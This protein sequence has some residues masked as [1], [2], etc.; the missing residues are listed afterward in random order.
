MARLLAAALLL[1]CA[2]PAAGGVPPPLRGA[3][4]GP[5]CRTSAIP[6]P[7]NALTAAAGALWLACRDGSRVECRGPSGSSSPRSG[8]RASGHGRLRAPATRCG[9]S[10]ATSPRSCAS[11]PGR[12]RSRSGSVCRRPRSTS[13][14]GPAA[15]RGSRS[16]GAGRWRASPRRR[17]ASA[18]ES[19]SATGRLASRPARRRGCCRIATAHSCASTARCR[20]LWADRRRTSS[21]RPSG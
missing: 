11:R 20:R 1:V 15:S 21:A 7:Q 16:T 13:G 10:T 19:S 14:V 5:A 18:R 9:W 4:V 8:H 2:V 3:Q 12:T 6:Y 17:T